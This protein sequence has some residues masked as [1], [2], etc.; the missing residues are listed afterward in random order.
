MK[1][2]RSTK[3]S[4]RFATASKHA[5]LDRVLTEYGRVCTRFVDL[6]W[7]MAEL[8]TKGEL[9]KPIVDSVP[10]WFSARLRKVAAREAIDM[11]KAARGR[12]GDKAVKPTHRGQ[13]MCLSSTI[14][15]LQ[16]ADE[17]TD[18]DAWLH[19]Q[20][21]GEKIVLDLPIRRHQHFNRLAVEG[22]RVESYIVTRDSVQFAFEVET[23]PKSE[24]AIAVGVDTGINALASLSTGEQLGTDVKA[25]IERIRRCKHGSKGQ[26]RAVRALRQRVDEV[27]RDVAGKADLVVVENLKNITK[28]TKRRGLGRKTR[29]SIGRWN[30][31]YW[32]MRLQQ[33]CE[34][35]RVTFRSVSPWRTSITCS[36]CGHVDRGNRNG[37][38]FCCSKCGY[39]ANADV[40]AS[41]NILTRFLTGPY[42]AG[43]KAQALS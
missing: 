28:G 41:R 18:F 42:G 25:H 12:W 21:I 3:C 43:C 32:L 29:Y 6:F 36:E 27:A 15:A 14:A 11:V 7:S 1:I 20:S 34:R 40:Q 39:Q 17:A 31:R 38:L 4:L 2:V 8:P 35:D 23:G 37:E 5:V 16:V 13:R 19:L 26:R 9:L 33:R 30:V 10:S 22:R 24:V